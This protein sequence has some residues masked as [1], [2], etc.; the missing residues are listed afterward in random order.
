MTGDDEGRGKAGSSI[1]LVWMMYVDRGK[2]KETGVLGVGGG[3]CVGLCVRGR[4][5]RAKQT[6]R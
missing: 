4:A 5:W 3:V 1:S 2:R 6:R